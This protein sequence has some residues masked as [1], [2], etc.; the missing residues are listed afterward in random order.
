MA[1]S[2][3]KI[4]IAVNGGM[5]GLIVLG[6]YNGLAG[7]ADIAPDGSVDDLATYSKERC[8]ELLIQ[9][10]SRYPKS[11]LW[12]LEE[13]RMEAANK[14]LEKAVDLLNNDEKSPLKQVAALDMFEKAL[15]SMYLHRYEDTA[16]FFMKVSP[17]GTRYS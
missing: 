2:N 11:H 10:R 15:D 6:Y 14:N 1:K 8:E 13:A 12:L 17:V 9:M 16:E 7:L 3:G 5:A 4:K